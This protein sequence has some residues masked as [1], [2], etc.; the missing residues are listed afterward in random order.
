VNGHVYDNVHLLQDNVTFKQEPLLF[1]NQHDGTYREVGQE[2]GE[3]FTERIVGRGCAWGDYDDDGGLDVLITE[4]NGPVRL[5]HNETPA[6]QEHHWLKF[7]LEGT[8]SNRNGIGA[9]II[10]RAGGRVQQ[11]EVKAGHSYLCQ[12][13]LRPHFGLGKATEA[14]EVEIRWPSGQVTRLHHVPANQI[15]HVREGETTS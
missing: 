15:L 5:W 13:D 11:R 3:P 9:R 7:V 14:E 2:A 6:A 1:W 8:Q 10:V 4:N 12:S